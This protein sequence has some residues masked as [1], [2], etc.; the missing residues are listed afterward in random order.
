M[1]LQLKKQHVSYLI[2]RNKV[3]KIHLKPRSFQNKALW[4]DILKDCRLGLTGF[5]LLLKITNQ[6]AT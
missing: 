3:A 6:Q 4:G 2:A 1:C 5:K